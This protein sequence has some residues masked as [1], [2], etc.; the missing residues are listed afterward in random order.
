MVGRTRQ[1]LGNAHS[2]ERTRIK[3]TIISN[4]MQRIMYLWIVTKTK[5]MDMINNN[6]TLRWGR[7]IHSITTKETKWQIIGTTI[8]T[9][10]TVGMITRSIIIGTNIHYLATIK[11]VTIT[12]KMITLHIRITIIRSNNQQEML[13]R[14]GHSSPSLT[15]MSNIINNSQLSIKI[16]KIPGPRHKHDHLWESSNS[17]INKHQATITHRIKHKTSLSKR[18]IFKPNKI[19]F[20]MI[21]QLL[22]N[23]LLDVEESST[24]TVSPSIRPFVIKSSKRKENNSMPNSKEFLMVSIKK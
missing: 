6:N 12:I 2:W 7:R 4:R 10:R 20:S 15:M 13:P 18:Q 5:I 9:L 3:T 19:S 14:P 1:I 24:L 22:F 21:P 11:I 23:A 8:T 17:T 16:N